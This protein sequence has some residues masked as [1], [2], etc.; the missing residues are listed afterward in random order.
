[1][2]NTPSLMSVSRRAAVVVLSCCAL[3]ITRTA[4]ASLILDSYTPQA[5]TPACNINMG[6]D[7]AQ[8]F[9]GGVG[10]NCRSTAL[11]PVDADV[12]SNFLVG[13]F[14]GTPP[15]TQTFGS[16]FDLWNAA[17]GAKAGGN[18]SLHFGG[19][20]DVTLHVTDTA[21]AG[22]N[23]GGI[24]PFT[25]SLANYHPK[26]DQPNISQLVWTQAV[27]MSYLPGF[28]A[29]V[30]PVD[31]NPPAN[32]LDTS[33]FNSFAP[34]MKLP[35]QTPGPFN[36]SFAK[37]PAGSPYCDPI[38]P[39]QL[40]DKSFDDAPLGPWPDESFRAI[41]LLSAVVFHTDDTG[42][43]TDRQLWVYNGVDWGYDL[44]V[45]EPSTGLVL[46]GPMAIVLIATIRKKSGGATA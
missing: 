17:N 36:T 13:N 22:A 27:Y 11:K 24:N 45:P 10:L 6:G 43:I 42:A 19:A 29:L 40:A 14:D 39:L 26:P 5:V 44:S 20:L 30:A 28:P 32:T 34:C 31:L 2:T 21:F 3:L 41:A 46:L 38:Y 37:I 23:L 18:W 9:P 4:R 16:T 7:H 12:N 8:T 33:S 25:I 15:S 1:M 35:G